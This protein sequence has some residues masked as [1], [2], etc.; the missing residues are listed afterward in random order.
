MKRYIEYIKENNGIIELD[1]S[2][3]S[4]TIL[5]VLPDE[6]EILYCASNKLKS[7]PVLPNRLKKLLCNNNQLETL[8]SS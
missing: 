3:K 2:S 5:P 7:L 1:Y 8:P 6:L 4:L